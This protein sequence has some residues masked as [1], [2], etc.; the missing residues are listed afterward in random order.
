MTDRPR[1]GGGRRPRQDADPDRSSR[2]GG[3][4]RR[5]PP[6][7]E[8]GAEARW[9]ADLVRAGTPVEVTLV[10]GET[11][12]GTVAEFDE[13]YLEIAPEDGAPV[14]IARGT[15]RHVAESATRSDP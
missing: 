6:P 4:G 9:Y 5:N 8:T 14:R 3:Y 7:D 13:Q 2:S 11:H 1:G 10:S 15:I 12:R